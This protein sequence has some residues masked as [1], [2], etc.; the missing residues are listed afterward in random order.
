MADDEINDS[1]VCN[2]IAI[3]DKSR[4]NWTRVLSCPDSGDDPGSV[5]YTSDDMNDTLEDIC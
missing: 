2:Y 4:I 1:A 3:D 5:L